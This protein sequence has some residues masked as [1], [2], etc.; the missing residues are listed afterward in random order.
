MTIDNAK[1]LVDSLNIV[2]MSRMN[3]KDLIRFEENVEIGQS[4]FAFICFHEVIGE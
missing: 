3:K 4:R 2:S 1:C